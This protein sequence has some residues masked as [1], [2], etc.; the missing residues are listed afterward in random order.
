MSND[1]DKT[2][3]IAMVHVGLPL[4]DVSRWDTN[5]TITKAMARRVKEME[6]PPD[7]YVQVWFAFLP[8]PSGGVTYSV[9]QGFYEH[10]DPNP[11]IQEV[12]IEP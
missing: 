9:Q 1:A 4:T 6:F 7:A 12:D 5:E 3:P 11:S 2:H 8:D 10:D